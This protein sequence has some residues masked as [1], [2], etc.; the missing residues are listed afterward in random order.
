MSHN[1]MW[2]SFVR[3]T[4]LVIEDEGLLQR[5]KGIG[6]AL[7]HGWR[8][9]SADHPGTIEQVRGRGAMV[10][11]QFA[12]A[13][14]ADTVVTSAIASGVLCMKAGRR[15]D[16]I[17]H[18]MPLVIADEQIGEALDVFATCVSRAVAD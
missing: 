9:I 18:L 16:V 14:F 7:T 2:D 5:A 12:D 11:V 6:E 13:A 15:G 3:K 10:G 1:Y 8:T 4:R 17:R